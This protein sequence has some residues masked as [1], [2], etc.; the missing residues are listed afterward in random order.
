MIAETVR[1]FGSLIETGEDPPGSLGDL[2]RHLRA[3]PRE[4]VRQ[5]IL[6]SLNAMIEQHLDEGDSVFNQ[7]KANWREILP[8]LRLLCLSEVADSQAMWAHYADQH[9]GA[10]LRFEC[11][12]TLDSAT[13]LAE[14]MNYRDEPPRLPPLEYWARSFFDLERIDWQEFF[15]EYHYVKTTEWSYEREWRVLSYALAHEEGLFSD[16]PFRARE[17]S[18]VI[19]GASATDLFIGELRALLQGDLAHVL[20]QQAVLDNASRKVSIRDLA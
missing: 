18:A 6:Q 20:L 1:L 16:T 3:D 8:K 14:P 15:H 5:A 4:E 12:D 19:V 13:L 10:V 2:V 9:R 7:F 11:L 17:L